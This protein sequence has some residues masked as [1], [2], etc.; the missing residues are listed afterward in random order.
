MLHI[1][2]PFEQGNIRICDLL[3]QVL[4]EHH[5]TGG[6]LQIDLSDWERGGYIL[7]GENMEGEKALPLKVIIAQ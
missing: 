6:S 2:A 5:F 1:E 4:R 7:Y 3:G